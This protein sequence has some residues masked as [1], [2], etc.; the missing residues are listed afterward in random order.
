MV[1]A[2]DPVGGGLVKS[3]ARP[4]GNITGNTN[5]LTDILPKQFEL[6]IEA[7]P[8]LARIAILIRGT[9]THRETLR[10]FWPWRPPGKSKCC[11]WRRIRCRRSR[12]VFR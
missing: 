6:L 9:Y 12:R 2:G 1:S 7:T 5:S 10:R 11:P 8:K 4:G 3:L